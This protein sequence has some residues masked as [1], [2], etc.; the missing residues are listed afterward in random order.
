MEEEAARGRP[1]LEG[2][3]L[4]AAATSGLCQNREPVECVLTGWESACSEGPLHSGEC[5]RRAVWRARCSL[6]GSARAEVGQLAVGL[7]LGHCLQFAVLVCTVLLRA[8]CR[9]G[10]AKCSARGRNRE[11][12]GK[13]RGN[14]GEGKRSATGNK[15]IN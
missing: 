2:P 1:Y 10:R 4:E 3:H 9:L 8:L 7:A 13:N 14:W 6:Q 11:N 15:M 5:L 12:W